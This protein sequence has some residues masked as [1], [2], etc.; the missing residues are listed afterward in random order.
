M[1]RR[2]LPS[3]LVVPA[4]RPALKLL[5]LRTRAMRSR[6]LPS[7]PVVLASRPARRARPRRRKTLL[8]APR[9]PSPGERRLLHPLSRRLQIR[10]RRKRS[11]KRKSLLPSRR[12][13]EATRLPRQTSPR[14]GLRQP[15]PR[16]SPSEAGAEL[17][18]LSSFQSLESIVAVPNGLT[19][20]KETKFVGAVGE[21][22]VP[23]HG[24]S[25]EI[26]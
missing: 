21:R 24:C 25:A 17:A 14:L 23:S 19:R 16:R 6:T 7:L 15:T 2:P 12:A 22:L 1:R 18:S 10:R 5:P 26:P 3:P 13:S 8:A 11:R 9:S 20:R 4:S